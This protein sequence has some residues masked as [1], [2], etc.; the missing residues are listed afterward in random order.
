MKINLPGGRDSSNS[1]LDKL[2]NRFRGVPTYLL[3]FFAILTCT[4]LVGLTYI[5]LSPNISL[6]DLLN[7]TGITQEANGE[8]NISSPY[9][10]TP[11]PLASGK[12]TYL[13]SGSKINAP[14]VAEVVIDPIDPA[15]GAN[16]KV[17]AQVLSLSGEPVTEVTVTMITDNK[18]TSYPLKLS[19]GTNLDGVWEASW[20]LSDT[21]LYL[22]QLAVKA[23]NAKDEWEVTI[24]FR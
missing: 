3:I 22:Y 12:Q 11:K 20:S 5:F 13:I 6:K 8:K 18:K 7:K 21:Y 9:K 19:S 17:L 1:L 4:I 16:Q 15:P 24:T 23:K 14:K 2:R 10:G